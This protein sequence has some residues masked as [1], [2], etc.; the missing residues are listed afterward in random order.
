MHP[1]FRQ[2]WREIGKIVV[3]LHKVLPDACRAINH[4]DHEVRKG[5]EKLWERS[6]RPRLASPGISRK[7]RFARLTAS[8][9]PS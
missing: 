3:R 5:D 7:M 4:E 9:M 1:I 2:A 8:Y 6:S